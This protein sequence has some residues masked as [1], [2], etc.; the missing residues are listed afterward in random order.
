MK[1]SIVC[2]LAVFLVLLS[3]VSGSLAAE[4]KKAPPPKKPAYKRIDLPPP[5]SPAAK[6]KVSRVRGFAVKGGLLGGAGAAEIG[7]LFP[8]G[9]VD[10][11][12]YAGYGVGSNYNILAVQLECLF[13]LAPLTLIPS[14]DY[15][16]Y[17][18]KVR[19]I[20][21]IAGDIDKGGHAGLGVAFGKHFGRWEGRLGYSTILGLTVTAGYKF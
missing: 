20:T 15:V 5:S 19:N 10:A 9:A 21:G 12:L 3:M 1:K 2:L 7:Y 6:A 13:K 18:E 11:G 4:K 16:N 14:I 17:S 8:V